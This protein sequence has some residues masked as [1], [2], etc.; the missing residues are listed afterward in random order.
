MN[1]RAIDLAYVGRPGLQ[2]PIAGVGTWGSERSTCALMN[3]V[4]LKEEMCN[5]R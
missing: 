1:N 5:D 2:S 4:D 3:P